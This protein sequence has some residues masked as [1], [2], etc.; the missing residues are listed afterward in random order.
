MPAAAVGAVALLVS[1][2]SSKLVHAP[3]VIVQRRVTLLPAVSPVTVLTSELRVV[4][5]AP[6]AAPMTDQ[7]PVPVTGVLAASVKLGVLHSS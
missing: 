2:T 1:T 7:R 3:L 6:F 5:V 4:T